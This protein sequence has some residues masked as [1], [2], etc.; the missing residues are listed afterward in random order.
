MRR[1]LTRAL[2]TMSLTVL[3]LM[4]RL[5]QAQEIVYGASLGGPVGGCSTCA[6]PMSSVH[7]C[8]KHHCPPPLKHC[9][10]RPPRIHYQHGCPKPICCPCDQPNWGYFQ[11]CWT[12]W[13]WPPDWSHCPVT[14]PAAFVQPGLMLPGQQGLG[15]RLPTITTP[16]GNPIPA[17]PMPEI[18]P[19]PRRLGI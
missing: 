9:L 18:T 16:P 14:P 10:E 2:V 12:P 7:C 13:P 1:F 17:Q 15:N 6:A 5:G 4:P 8:Q 19:A 11:T 3:G